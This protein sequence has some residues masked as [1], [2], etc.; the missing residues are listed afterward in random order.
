[1]LRLSRNIRQQSHE[2]RA[3]YRSTEIPLEFG[4]DIRALPRKDASVRIQKLA[5]DI[6][7]LVVYELD[8]MLIEITLLFHDDVII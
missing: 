6:H 2:P 4:R 5:E 8:I 3:L 1:L 7:I